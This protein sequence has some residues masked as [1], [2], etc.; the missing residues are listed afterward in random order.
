VRRWRGGG[1]RGGGGSSSSV[2]VLIHAT[3]TSHIPAHRHTHINEVPLN[4]V[5]TKK[6]YKKQHACIISYLSVANGGK[7]EK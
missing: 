4:K 3:C 1:G 7:V 5:Q 2:S 6:T